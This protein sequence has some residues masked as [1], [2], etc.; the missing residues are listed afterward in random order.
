MATFYSDLPVVS[1]FDRIFDLEHYREAP[2]DWWVVITDVKGS[3]KAIQEGR[4]RAVNFVGAITIAAAQNALRP[5]DI[6]FVFGGD[7]ATLLVPDSHRALLGSVLLS[8]QE[9]SQQDFDLELRVGMVSMEEIQAAGHHV[10]VGK[11]GASPHYAQAL[12]IGGGLAYAEQLIKDPERTHLYEISDL[13]PTEADFTGVECRWQ[14][15]ANP[16]GETVS[17]LIGATSDNPEQAGAV[18]R[19]ILKTLNE[20]YGK[21]QLT[22]PI[23]PS[24]LRPSFSMKHLGAMEPHVRTSKGRRW[25]YT[26][27]MW[28]QQFVLLFLVRFKIKTGDTDWDTYFPIL[29]ETSDIR[30]FDE[31]LRMVIASTPEK[32]EQFERYLEAKYQAGDLVYGVHVAD[33]ALLTCVVYERVG[34]QVH[35]VDG[36]DGGYAM[37]AKGLKRRIRDL[38]ERA[39][40]H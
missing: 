38:A 35:F 32:R 4:Y 37:A 16:Y 6:P 2:A 20:T 11:F 19:D 1:K 29:S 26:L 12:F 10:L 39:T 34:N 7:G 9:T 25:L 22:H 8:V 31:M 28:L 40:T 5:L 24:Y 23:L 14:N 17:L 33:S 13:E 15:I 30:K 21:D 18:Y 36:A 27:K 3:T